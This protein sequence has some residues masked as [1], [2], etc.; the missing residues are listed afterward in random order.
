MEETKT[1]GE[2]TADDAAKIANSVFSNNGM[3]SS[4]FKLLYQALTVEPENERASKVLI[5]VVE[6]LTNDRVTVALADHLLGYVKDA[7]FR[8][9]ISASKNFA[10]YRLGLL[11]HKSPAVPPPAEAWEDVEN[12]FVLDNDGYEN[13]RRELLLSPRE[14]ALFD[15]IYRLI[16]VKSG[17]L[18]KVD[19]TGEATLDDMYTGEFVRTPEY[20]EFLKSEKLQLD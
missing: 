14:G 10:L 1:F 18:K 7:H 4:A 2:I 6:S 11:T 13:L 12:E 16:G 9:L 20:E 8:K 17:L 3:Q 19:F 15:A 5:G